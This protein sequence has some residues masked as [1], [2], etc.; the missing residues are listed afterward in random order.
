MP[1]IT[2]LP[3]D[4]DSNGW[5]RTIGSRTPRP[6]LAG[7]HKADVLVIG[8]GYA[9]LAAAWR[10]AER[11]PNE[12]VILL[13]A[14]TIGDGASGRNSGFVLGV[15]HAA[16]FANPA[17]LEPPKRVRRIS[18]AAMSFLDN[19][20]TTHQIRCDWKRD[21][22]HI[23]A[24]G[25]WGE[26]CLGRLAKELDR[27]EEPHRML[28]RE[29]ARRETGT[30]HYRSMLFSPNC[31]LF[32]PGKLIHGLADTLPE[33]VRLFEKSP[34]IEIDYGPPVVA[35]TPAGTVSAPKVVL[36][37]NGLA[38]QF[39]FWR[40]RIFPLQ[41]FA[42]LTRPLTPAEQQALGAKP[43]GILPSIHTTS[44]TLRYTE[45]HR[46]LVRAQYG[47]DVRHA[48]AQSKYPLARRL[49]ERMLRERFP[50]L[51]DLTFEHTWCGI[52]CLSRNYAHGLDQPAPHVFTAVCE[53]G[54]GATKS[55]VSGLCAADMAIGEPN[56][57]I[58][59]M[60]AFGRPS[61]LPPRPLFE[62][63]FSVRRNYEAWR[64]RREA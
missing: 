7:H 56:P 15:R 3:T 59:D 57:L 43:W 58:A 42:S 39:G 25:A 30:A 17:D 33:S 35:R 52:V 8:A 46:I 29:E 47:V 22:M 41:L 27:L 62:A 49:H 20:V 32:H 38:P 50:M 51:P 40:D 1:K 44:P 63:A 36:A 23:A 19:I 26:E 53:N 9:G 28:G 10:L 13:E 60:Q 6:T 64:D 5:T 16:M 2:T 34:V 54:V 37:V 55:V 4:D 31:V 14:Q 12:R 21:G 45:D 11:R 48:P 24:A 18:Q 61:R